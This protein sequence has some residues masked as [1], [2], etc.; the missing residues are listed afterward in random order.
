MAR[1]GFDIHELDEFTDRLIQSSK[2]AKK[3]QRKFLQQQGNK[4]KR[5]TLQK[6]RAQVNKVRVERKTYTREAGT[7]HK[8]IKRGKVHVKNGAQ[9]VRVYSGD[10][11]AHLIEDGWTPKLRN[12]KRGS[13][14]AGKEIFEQAH[15]DFAPVFQKACEEEIDEMIGKL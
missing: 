4:L 5:K 10:P 15:E 12:G 3:A 1:E 9:R 13:K 14:Q 8:S 7:Y 11:V 6:A 2:E